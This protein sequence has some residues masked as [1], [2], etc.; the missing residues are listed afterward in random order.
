MKIPGSIS[1]FKDLYESYYLEL[2][3]FAEAILF[4][5]DEGEDVVQEVFCYLYDNRRNI[6]IGSNLRSYLFTSVKNRSLN[7][8]KRVKLFDQN[9]DRIKEAYLFL[10][11]IDPSIDEKRLQRIYELSESF[12]EK[13]RK[14][15]LLRIREGKRYEEVANEMGISVNSVK[16]HLKR[17][18]NILRKS[19]S[20][21]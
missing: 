11:N 14:A 6:Y 20:H 4:D 12:P 8:I 17:A 21:F 18:F 13:M 2:V 7:R 1:F 5:R 9:S 16:T 10:L 3:D 15:F 19:Q